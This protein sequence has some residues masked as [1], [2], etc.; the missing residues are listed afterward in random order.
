[1]AAAPPETSN[2]TDAAPVARPRG[3]SAAHLALKR[4]A[5][6]WAQENDY[7]IAALEVSLPKCRYRADVAAYRP[8]K[9]DSL[10]VTA[11]FECKQSA[12]DLRRDDRQT[13]AT[14]ARLETLFRRRQIL[15]KHLRVHYPTLRTGETLFPEWDAWNFAA[16]EHRGYA[17]V[18]RELAA[19]QRQL[20]NGRKFE[21]I[22]RYAC[23]NLFYLVAPDELVDEPAAPLGWGL[24]VEKSGALTLR[25][26]P[27][28]QESSS[29]ARLHVLQKI[30]AAGTREINRRHHLEPAIWEALQRDRERGK[31]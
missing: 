28:W 17:R 6:V 19:L 9:G 8:E 12:P 22:A 20:R 21:K 18:A 13:A 16:T 14:H 26:K 10:G 11:I 30:A 4:L 29:A 5:L 24:L 25:R 15:E 23:A 27:I 7:R 31:D 3:E 1:M 2:Q